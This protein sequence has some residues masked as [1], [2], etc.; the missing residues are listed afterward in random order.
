MSDTA[1]RS[2]F[3]P[4]DLP[5]MLWREGVLMAAVF[6]LVLLLGLVLVLASPTRYTAHSSLLI[7]LGRSY[8]YQPAV[9]DAARG[10]APDRRRKPPHLCGGSGFNVAATY[11]STCVPGSIIGP[12]E[13]NCRVR[14]GNG[15]GLQ[16]IATTKS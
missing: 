3:A 11:F 9:G 5:A 16:G 7:R 1:D 6:A 2:W 12:L 8:I 10:A 13:L 4:R 15:C 14:N